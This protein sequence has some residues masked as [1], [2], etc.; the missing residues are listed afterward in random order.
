V[1]PQKSELLNRL[2]TA[3]THQEQVA[4]L[5]QIDEF[6]ARTAAATVQRSGN[7]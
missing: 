5:A 7:Y 2:R 1:N 3:K 4:L 6:D